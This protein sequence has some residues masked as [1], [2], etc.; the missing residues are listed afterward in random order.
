MIAESSFSQ[1]KDTLF[2]NAGSTIVGEV[3]KIK[4]GV[5]TFDPDDANDITVQL[6]NLKTLSAG[7]EVFRI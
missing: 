2:F 3:K 7:S 6:R 4:L 5:V 1:K